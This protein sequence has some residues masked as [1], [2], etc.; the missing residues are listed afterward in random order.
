LPQEARITRLSTLNLDPLAHIPSGFTALI[1]RHRRAPKRAS[2]S[3]CSLG[4]S[5]EF[6]KKY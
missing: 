2:L 5:L 3:G 4:K 1:T 6:G